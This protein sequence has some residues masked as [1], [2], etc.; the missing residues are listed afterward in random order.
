MVDFILGDILDGEK[1]SRIHLWILFV[2]V[3]AMSHE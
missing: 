1:K 2:W 3:E